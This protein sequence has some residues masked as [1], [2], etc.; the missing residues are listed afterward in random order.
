M[1]DHETTVNIFVHLLNTQPSLFSAEDRI[2]L[3]KLIN[4]QPDDIIS[5]SNAISDWLSEHPEV[6]KALAKLEKIVV[7]GPGDKQANTNI[8]KYELDK[9][10]ILNEI[11]QSSSS[12]KETKKPT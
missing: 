12:A 9:K 10:N 11:Q 5:L 4:N 6:D 3:I 1:S 7:R 2:T 8:P